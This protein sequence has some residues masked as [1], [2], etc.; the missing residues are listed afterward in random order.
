M[1]LVLL[2]SPFDDLSGFNIDPRG[3]V[4]GTLFG[5]PV[6]T[7]PAQ[8]QETAGILTKLIQDCNLRRG[9]ED[10]CQRRQRI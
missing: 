10:C 4:G 9:I 7:T 5:D 6:E 8:A 2:A 3:S 1:N